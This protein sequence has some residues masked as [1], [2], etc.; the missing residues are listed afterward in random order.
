M[1]EK[2]IVGQ[3]PYD[4]EK[5]QNEIPNK[6]MM[7][8]KSELLRFPKYQKLNQINEHRNQNKNR[9]LAF[10]YET[11]AVLGK[12]Q[13]SIKLR[14]LILRNA[15]NFYSVL[16]YSTNHRGVK[17]LIPVSVYLTCLEHF[18]FVRRKEFYQ[19][20][21][22][23]NFDRCLKAILIKNNTLR[24][25]LLSKDFRIKTIKVQLNGLQTHFYLNGLFFQKAFENLDKYFNKVKNAMNTSIT[26][27]IFDLTAHQ[28]MGKFILMSEVCH[29]LGITQSTVFR[30]RLY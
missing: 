13:L 17:V 1:I 4:I 26:A 12:L 9:E 5:R 11:S 16:G 3:I 23:H 18:I 27:I 20:C 30:R 21:T 6:N 19:F 14:A 24:L 29:F 25:K 7:G 8:F 22:K 28:L 10:Y 15:E 2:E